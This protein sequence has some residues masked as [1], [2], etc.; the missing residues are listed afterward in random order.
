MLWWAART[1]ASLHRECSITHA[2]MALSP[3]PWE[4]CFRAALCG[5]LTFTSKLPMLR[6]T[7]INY[8]TYRDLPAHAPFD[9]IL[10]R[11]VLE[12]TYDPLKFLQDVGDLMN[13]GGVL[14]IEVPNL[15]A[16]LRRVFGKY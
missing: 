14:M 12:H 1:C 15:H 4:H 9:L 11:H 6:G 16:P 5:Q 8:A 2:A 3:S 7:D 10:C 13:P